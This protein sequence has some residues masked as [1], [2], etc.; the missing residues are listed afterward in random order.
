MMESASWID[1]K[2]YPFKTKAEQ[3]DGHR[4]NYIDE[5]SGEV[6]LF[7]HGT[8]SWSFEYR[9]VIH[10]LQ[11]KYRCIAPDYLGFGLSDK[12]DNIDYR[13]SGHAERLKKFITRLRL[14]KFHLVVHDFGG[15]IGLSV[16][17]EKPECVISLKIIN[18]WLWSLNEYTH[19][20]KPAKLINTAVGKF[21]YEKL[22]FSANFLLKTGF[23][24]KNK[25]TKD[26]HNHYKN[27]QDKPAR[28]AAYQFALSLLGES[29][30]Y[31]NLWT[32][33]E[34][35]RNIPATIIWGME[36]KLL[37][38]NV[39]LE[40]WRNGFPDATIIE[41]RDAGHFPQEESVESVVAAIE[42]H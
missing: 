12:P 36:D 27:A 10:K 30:W 21:L 22:N 41:I 28:K 31:N 35:I 6:I 16:A 7:I 32:N 39:L 24:N 9:N 5:G 2:H 19:F 15:P 26:I 25:L 3:I 20:Q 38:A 23:L 4:M 34:K 18:T 13:P 33:R 8:P 29:E 40:K 11:S 42:N 37:P 1:K 17:L 14:T